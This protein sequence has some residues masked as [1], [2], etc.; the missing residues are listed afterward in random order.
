MFG[1]KK[2]GFDEK[3]ENALEGELLMSEDILQNE[4]EAERE[5]VSEE[6]KKEKKKKEKKKKKLKTGERGY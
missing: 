4:E 1:K 5:T 6:G 3:I 2:K